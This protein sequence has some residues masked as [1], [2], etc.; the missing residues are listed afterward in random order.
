MSVRSVPMPS[1]PGGGVS[2]GASRWSAARAGDGP[3]WWMRNAVRTAAPIAA[4]SAAST[5]VL[6]CTSLP[7]VMRALP[8]LGVRLPLRRPL[9][10]RLGGPV[11]SP[12]E[13]PRRGGRT[14]SGT[15]R[16]ALV[17][18]AGLSTGDTAGYVRKLER[19]VAANPRD[20]DA[21]TLLGLSYQQR[22][23]ETGD[24][25]FYKLSGE[26]LRRAANAGGQRPL[27]VQ[28]Q[29]ALANTRHRFREGRR[30]AR[31]AIRLA[32]DNGSA[33]GALGDSL[34][35]LGRYRPAF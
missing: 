33:Y 7:A 4:T 23:R 35:N 28:G 34:L 5:S 3:A 31:L 15:R 1:P 11:R 16:D 22:A 32:P 24:P 17:G 8:S 30:L 19:R 2:P 9:F 12:T 21:L 18:L 14:S 26:A 20:A 27:I 10:A 25:T 13:P 29:A 6:R